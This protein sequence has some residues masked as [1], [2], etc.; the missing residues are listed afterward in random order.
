MTGKRKKAK[1]TELT[2]GFL[3]QHDL[4]VQNHKICQYLDRTKSH[5]IKSTHLPD[6]HIMSYAWFDFIIS[7]CNKIAIQGKGTYGKWTRKP[8]AYR[9]S[10]MCNPP[11][12]DICQF[13]FKHIYVHI[14]SYH[15][16]SHRILYQIISYYIIHTWFYSHSN[17]SIYVK[18]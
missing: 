3:K 10:S 7:K 17:Y 9:E 8:L 4:Y 16:T 15:I 6:S 2:H 1:Y 12:W 13:Y 11:S 18:M 5:D 14:I